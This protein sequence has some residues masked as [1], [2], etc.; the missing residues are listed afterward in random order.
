MRP[1]PESCQG[2][3]LASQ[4]SRY[5]VGPSCS[6]PNSLQVGPLVGAD[7]LIG[8]WELELRELP[9]RGGTFAG[10]VI[11]EGVCDT[12]QIVPMEKRKKVCAVERAFREL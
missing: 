9:E 1:T 8:T 12:K 11:M 7:D 5:A 3:P 2:V 6:L 10:R 4:S